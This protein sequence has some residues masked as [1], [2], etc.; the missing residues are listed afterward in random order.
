MRGK[1][2]ITKRMMGLRLKLDFHLAK[3]VF[4]V[5]TKIDVSKYA[6]RVSKNI[7]IHFNFFSYSAYHTTSQIAQ[8]GGYR[9]WY[10]NCNVQIRIQYAFH[11]CLM[12]IWLNPCRCTLSGLTFAWSD[13]RGRIV[14]LL[15]FL[16]LNRLVC[17]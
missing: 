9:N 8:N 12:E 3:W 4:R 14:F 10:A 6:I 13:F 16:F 17:K 1:S 11:F 5:F 2:T 7:W 15:I